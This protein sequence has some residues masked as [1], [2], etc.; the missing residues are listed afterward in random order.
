MFLRLRDGIAQ[1]NYKHNRRECRGYSKSFT[2]RFISEP[3]KSSISHAKRLRAA[4]V[5]NSE[6]DLP[7]MLQSYV[8]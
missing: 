2:H 1:H 3:R 7:H 6:P 4:K 5:A 8:M